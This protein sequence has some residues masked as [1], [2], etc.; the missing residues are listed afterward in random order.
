[1]GDMSS[2]TQEPFYVGGTQASY[3]QPL[4][5]PP[6]LPYL[7]CT[8]ENHHVTLWLCI[9]HIASICLSVT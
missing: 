5:V 4:C 6:A 7:Q 8:Q 9:L 1:M 2:V 3:H